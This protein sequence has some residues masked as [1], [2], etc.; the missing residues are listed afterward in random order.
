MSLKR[1]LELLYEI[2]ALRNIERTWKQFTGVK[3]ENL[4][5]HMFRVIWI[6]MIIAK[7]EK[8][9][10]I[11]KIMKMALVHD[12]SESRTGDAHYVANQY[13]KRDEEGAVKD[14]LEETSLK[15]FQELWTEFENR[16]SIEAKIVKDADS[17]D[18][19][20][21]L[22]E[23]HFAGHKILEVLKETRDAAAKKLHTDTARELRKQIME[24]N[25]HDW[26]L[27]SKNRLNSGDWKPEQNP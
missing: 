2:G 3:M 4:S 11:N 22:R 23:L 1:D 15:E 25:P 18:Q 19:D 27:N 24:S 17:L 5:E 20:L 26:H 12:I 14:M 7:N 21:E 9:G 10:D 16:E 8:V 13:T 6:A